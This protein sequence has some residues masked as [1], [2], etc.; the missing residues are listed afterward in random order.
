M[1]S[2]RQHPSV[3]REHPISTRFNIA[4][5]RLFI[6]GRRPDGYLRSDVASFQS[7]NR[8]AFH[9]RTGKNLPA[10]VT[11]VA[12][13]QYRHRDAFHFRSRRRSPRGTGFYVSI[14][15]SRCFSFQVNAV[16]NRHRNLQSFNLAIERL[17]IS[18]SML[19]ASER[20][21]SCF[22]LAIERLFISGS[23]RGLRRGLPRYRFNLAIE[24]LFISGMR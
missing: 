10:A 24:M 12:K 23:P 6:L 21:V 20:W 5:E 4:I 2:P 16:R 9:F 8:D 13:F 11:V 19:R 18:G 17:F 14:S 15:P 3:G 7:R 22:N 1:R